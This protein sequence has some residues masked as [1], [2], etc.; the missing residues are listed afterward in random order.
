M[1]SVARGNSAQGTQHGLGILF[2]CGRSEFA[3]LGGECRVLRV[4]PGKKMRR[5]RGCLRG[6]AGKARGNAAEC[7]VVRC[8]E[9]QQVKAL[10][11]RF[12]VAQLAQRQVKGGRIQRFRLEGLSQNALEYLCVGFQPG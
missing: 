3:D 4:E 2:L 7:R 12:A 1:A 6:V 10:F 9:L 8:I 5:N 11:R